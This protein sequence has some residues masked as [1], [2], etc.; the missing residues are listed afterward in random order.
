MDDGLVDHIA[1]TTHA[2]EEVVMEMIDSGIFEAITVSYH[3]LKREREAVMARAHE[4]GV[5]VVVMNPMGGGI[6]GHESDVIRDLLPE[7]AL[8]SSA[9]ALKF[10]LDHPHVTC[11]ICGF[12]KTSD[13]AENVAAAE[14]PALGQE[15]RQLIV[16]RLAELDE[17]CAEFCTQCGYCMPCTQGVD[18]RGIFNLVNMARLF[19]LEDYARARYARMKPETKA[20]ICTECG[21][22]EEKCTNMLA[23]REELKRADALLGG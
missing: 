2:P 5:A 18:I 16:E 22:C 14:A 7:S 10:V 21:E 23:I 12:A 1:A 17:K 13:V 3:M 20:D 19:G 15:Q 11:A 9:L 4:K 6:L 8:S